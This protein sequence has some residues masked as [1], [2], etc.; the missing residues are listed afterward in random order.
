MFGAYPVKELE[1]SAKVNPDLLTPAEEDRS[2]F[3]LA[4]LF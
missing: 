1:V 2:G 4:I 3:K